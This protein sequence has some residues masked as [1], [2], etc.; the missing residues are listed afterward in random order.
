MI[1]NKPNVEL[2]EEKEQGIS[3]ED[4]YT[5]VREGIINNVRINIKK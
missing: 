3:L 2:D 4:S 5:E 1:K